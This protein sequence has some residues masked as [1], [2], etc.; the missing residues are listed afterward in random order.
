MELFDLRLTNF[1]TAVVKRS[2]YARGLFGQNGTWDFD[3][4]K[5][6][7]PQTNQVDGYGRSVIVLPAELTLCLKVELPDGTYRVYD[8]QHGDYAAFFD[9]DKNGE[10]FSAFSDD[11]E[12]APLLNTDD[13][14]IVS[15]YPPKTNTAE[16]KTQDEPNGVPDGPYMVKVFPDSEPVFRVKKD[17]TWST[18]DAELIWENY[19]SKELAK[20]SIYHEIVPLKA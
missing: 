16:P 2:G 9:I 8:G 12:R 5:N 17:G 14:T 11:G 20:D 3:D 19:G 4:E 13:L 7:G 18:W 1:D 10:A 6:Y 15:Y